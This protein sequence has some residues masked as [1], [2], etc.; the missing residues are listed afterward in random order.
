MIMPVSNLTK[1]VFF[2]VVVLCQVYLVY[3]ATLYVD[4]R[5]S[6]ILWVVATAAVCAVA[7]LYYIFVALGNDDVG[8]D[9]SCFNENGEPKW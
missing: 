4:I 7:S 3:A 8:G 6:S 9:N 2:I 1:S 5:S